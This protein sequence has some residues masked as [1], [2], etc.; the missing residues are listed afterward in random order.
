MDC[1][2]AATTCAV[3][4]QVYVCVC[5]ACDVCLGVC[6][7]RVQHG[8]AAVQLPDPQG[9]TQPPVV[10]LWWAT[11]W[12]TTAATAQGANSTAAAAASHCIPPQPPQQ[13]QHK[14]Q[15]VLQ[16]HYVIYIC[17]LCVRHTAMLQQQPD[18][19]WQCEPM[20]LC[21]AATWLVVRVMVQAQAYMHSYSHVWLVPTRCIVHAGCSCQ[22]DCSLQLQQHSRLG[23]PGNRPSTAQQHA[24]RHRGTA[25]PASIP[26]LPQRHL[27]QLPARYKW[28]G[29]AAVDC[30]VPCGKWLLCRCEWRL[31]GI[32]NVMQQPE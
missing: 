19:V 28:L 17:I 8:Q 2:F 1:Q 23:S 11:R 16:Q 24:S 9:E 20:P 4:P 3:L 30:E 6:C 29:A 27:Q 15:A 7:F 14:E 26:S 13:Q 21:T 32:S 18:F 22:P 25:R 31:L 10:V 12:L 5:A